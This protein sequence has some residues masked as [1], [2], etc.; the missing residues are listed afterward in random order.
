MTSRRNFLTLLG[1]GAAATLLGCDDG[2]PRPVADPGATPDVLLVDTVAGL[3]ILRGGSADAWGPAVATP[4][5]HTIF[6]ARTA[7]TDTELRTL[8]ARS[9]EVA[10]SVRLPGRWFPS[11]AGPSGL[12]ALVAPASGPDAYP[13]A[14]RDHT[15]LLIVSGD[16]VR[17]LDL[18]GNYVPD[19]FTP[20]GRGLFVLDWLPSTAPEHY[21]V[22]EVNVVSGAVS[23][24]YGR[25]KQPIPPEAEE[26]MRGVRRNAVFGAGGDVLYTLYTHQPATAGWSGTDN[27]FIHTLQL[28]Q[29]WA[30][31]VDL[32]SPFGL[33]A[34]A[35][36][37][38]AIDPSG[39]RLFV[40]D[41][42]AGKLAV[43]DTDSLSVQRTVDVPRGGGPAY[44]AY[45]G[46][47]LH[48]A[49]DTSVVTI[50][51]RDPTGRPVWNLPARALGLAS[52]VDGT[53]MYVGLPDAVEWYGAAG[54]QRLGRV[55]VTGLTGLRQAV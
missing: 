35:S 41:A 21:R 24:L 50:A 15:S 5:G 51:G 23:A 30:Y 7:G 52:N 48:L 8:S 36:H 33:D 18:A 28:D 13:P 49:V 20:D 46:E 14:G 34:N 19:A 42:A 27:A 40:V 16:A 1:A 39:S 9:G 31:C 17:R 32:P 37:A 55:P 12:V 29:H 43:V 6:A 25:D 26:Q 10:R 3:V 44:L 22:R 38:L 47:A 4:D 2:A 53:R 54:G 11:A 45:A